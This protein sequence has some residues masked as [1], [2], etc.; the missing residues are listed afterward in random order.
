MDRMEQTDVH[1]ERWMRK[2]R[3]RVKIE[4]RELADLRRFSRQL[5]ERLGRYAK[6]T[7][8][9]IA[10]LIDSRQRTEARLRAF[11]GCGTSRST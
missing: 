9:K 2:I 4:M 8:Q 11:V 5:G 7:D 6:E 1:F 10:A 3:R